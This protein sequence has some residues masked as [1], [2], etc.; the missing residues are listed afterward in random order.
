VGVTCLALFTLVFF[1]VGT[2]NASPTELS[3]TS[4]DATVTG[5]SPTTMSFPLQRSGD[6]GYD[7]WLHYETE[8]GTAKAGTDYSAASGEVKVPAGSSEKSISVQVSGGAAFAPDKQFALKLLSATGI[9]P[10]PS[11][12]E[13]TSFAAG[14]TVVGRA[15]VGDLNGD[16]R[17]DAIIPNYIAGTISILLDATP[18]G[19]ST[20]SLASAQT[21]AVGNHPEAATP[22]DVNGDGLPDLVVANSGDDDFSVLLNATPPGASTLSFAP[23]QVFEA[24]RGPGLPVLEDING[25]GRPDLILANNQFDER[26][27]SVF[28]NTTP[29]GASTT[30]FQPRQYF[31]F[32]AP[33]FVLPADINGDGRPD[34]IISSQAGADE[35]VAILNET[36]PGGSNLVLG[37]EADLPVGELPNIVRAADLNGDGRPDLVVA[38]NEGNS[39][40]VLFNSTAPGASTPSFASQR[41]FPVGKTPRSLQVVDLNGDGRVD[42]VVGNQGNHSL[43]ALLNTTAPGASA[44]SFSAQTLEAEPGPMGLTAADFNG[45]GRQD[46]FYTRMSGN[47]ALVSM[48]TTAAPTGS[49]PS[50]AAKQDAA[51]GGRPSSVAATDLNGDGKPDLVVANRDDDDV[52]VRLDTTPPGASTPSFAAQQTFVAG[53]APTSVASADLNHDGR[54]DLVVSDEFEENVSVL[55][56]TTAPGAGTPSFAARQTFA[57]GESPSAVATADFNLDGKPDLVVANHD[58]DDV[59]VLLDTT[60]PGAS[61]PGFAAQQTFAAGESPSGV[62]AADLNGDGKPDLVVVNN[63]EDTA[64]VLFNTTTPGA[65]TSSFAAQQAFGTE[66]HPSSVK[67]TDLNGDGIPDLVVTNKGSD[68]AS[69]LFNTTTLG[70]L[71]P[72]FALP[73]SFEAG[74]APSAVTTADLNGD[75]IPDL[76]VTNGGADTVSVLLNTTAPGAG[77]PS[78]AAQQAFATGVGPSSV[79]TADLNG[80]GG[81]DIVAADGGA[82][83]ISALLDTQYA[84]SVSPM[85]VTGTIH[86]ALPQG[87]LSP[88]SLAFGEQ[89]IG[90]GATKVVSLSNTGGATLAINGIAVGGV[91]AAEFGQTNACPATLEP[92]SSCSVNVGFA[93][94]TTGAASAVLTVTSNDPAS[95]NVMA[96]SGTG[97]TA[98][99]SPA[100]HMLTIKL[101]GGGGGRVEGGAGTIS[102]PSACSH[103]FAD[104]TQV[105]LAATPAAGSTFVGWSGGGCASSRT[106]EVTVG[107]D[108]TVSATFAKTPPADARLRFAKTTE[109][110]A[111]SGLRIAVRGTIAKGASGAVIVKVRVHAHGRW[112]TVSRRAKIAD[113]GWRARLVVAGDPGP[114][115]Y[116]SARFGGSPGFRSD[117]AQRRF[118]LG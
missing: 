22:A 3:T 85:S 45:D 28:F 39:I 40:S 60:V 23:A 102:C 20:P 100:T 81:P 95:P 114:P 47:K 80:D 92:G 10:T 51:A 14:G 54:P 2:A 106:C 98:T 55:L 70:T 42:L 41:S 8:D 6:L 24:G 15:R 84:A 56:A 101:N 62:A 99:S 97:I 111:R 1:L 18:P 72:S 68:S 78:F 25:D 88:G 48:N 36:P 44:P 94:N 57:A 86:Y 43:T 113:G 75:G 107:A 52:S 33:G 12:A 7:T 82:D 11:F 69:V 21:F 61:T 58:E 67:A 79:T 46:L 91:S 38:N 76:L 117:H 112:V 29:P 26:A 19:A 71:T 64:S 32:F 49:A 96:L 34:L 105:T 37:S 109:T 4:A 110:T 83:A 9:G 115:I 73:H 5:A 27:I 66:E 53:N 104:G 50:L 30:S 103:P 118:A 87:T 89:V 13:R 90:S 74:D 116:M 59:S 16:G 65:A 35:V 77:T 63:D 31:E 108:T 93:P 17:P